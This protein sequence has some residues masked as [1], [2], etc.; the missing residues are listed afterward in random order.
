MSIIKHPNILPQTSNFLQKRDWNDNYWENSGTA[1]WAFFAIFIVLVIIVILGTIRVN[2]KRS[3]HGQQPLYGTRWMTPPSYRQSQN[4][5]DQPDH[6]R[7]PDL[8]SA[9][10]PTYTAQANEYDMGYYDSSG[11]F[12]ANPNAKH[13]LQ[14]P[15]QTHQRNISRNSNTNIAAT[16][17]P[18]DI[19]NNENNNEDDIG[20][21]SRPNGPPPSS[22]RNSISQRRDS[23]ISNNN[24]N[25]NNN[26]NEIINERIIETETIDLTTSSGSG[27]DEFTRPL[28]P[29]PSSSTQ[30]VTQIHEF[31]IDSKK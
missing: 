7:D 17:L 8:P 5:Y 4:Q 29:P 3:Q 30:K 28:G 16:N 11:T 13:A 27:S 1:R 2:K 19:H 21:I 26:N 10:V 14:H 24:S 18:T 6:V 15:P 25:N 22:Q 20:D 31:I 23:N 12:I 9:Y